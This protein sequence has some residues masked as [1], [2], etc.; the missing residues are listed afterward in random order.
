MLRVR[1]YA[2]LPKKEKIIEKEVIK[3][4]NRPKGGPGQNVEDYYDLVL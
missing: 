3:Y 4:V 2:S 1:Y